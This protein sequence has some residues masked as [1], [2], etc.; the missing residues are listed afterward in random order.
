M[1]PK[2]VE[3]ADPFAPEYGQDSWHAKHPTTGLQVSF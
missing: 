1:R 3:E 2:K